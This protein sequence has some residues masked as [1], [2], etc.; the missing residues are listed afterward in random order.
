MAPCAGKELV[1]INSMNIRILKVAVILAVV[2]SA[3]STTGRIRKAAKSF[4]ADSSLAGSNIG[5]SIFDPVKKQV[6]L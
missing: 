1:E 4:Y 2:A 6:Y 5:V 3:C